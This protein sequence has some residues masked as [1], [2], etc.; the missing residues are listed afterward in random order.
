MTSL[1]T[2]YLW[3]E[4]SDP[5]PEFGRMALPPIFHSDT[6]PSTPC[7][8]VPVS[9]YAGK[10][11]PRPREPRTTGKRWCG[12]GRRVWNE[13]I[14]RCLYTIWEHT[15]IQSVHSLFWRPER[16]HTPIGHSFPGL[17]IQGWPLFSALGPK[18]NL[19]LIKF[20]MRKFQI[21]SIR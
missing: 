16:S 7:P 3:P 4:V 17:R 2:P 10:S 1:F 21:V 14:H 9:L 11:L 8:R 18:W 19:K 13:R 5:P 15:G 20:R 12:G 6:P